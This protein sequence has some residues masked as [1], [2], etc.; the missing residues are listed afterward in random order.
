MVENV[1]DAADP[2][3]SSISSAPSADVNLDIDTE[4]GLDI[5]EPD[6]EGEDDS[7][8]EEDVNVSE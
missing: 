5:P 1:E 2:D 7:L 8:I 4:G 6:P 3:D